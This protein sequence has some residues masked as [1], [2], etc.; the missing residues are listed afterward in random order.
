M[1]PDNRPGN[2]ARELAE[3]M[4]LD[5]YEVSKRVSDLHAQNLIEVVETRRCRVTN[6]LARTWRVAG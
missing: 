1:I 2:T 6:R 4:D 3:L 5:A